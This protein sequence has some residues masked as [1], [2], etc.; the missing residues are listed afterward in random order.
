ML[1]PGQSPPAEGEGSDSS[2]SSSSTGGGS[3]GGHGLSTGAIVGIAIS[4]TAFV[5]ILVA[6]FFFIGRNRVYHHWMSSEDGR[7]E[8]TA[9]WLFQ[10]QTGTRD[11][12]ESSTTR[13]PPTEITTISSPDSAKGLLTPPMDASPNYTTS[14][15]HTSGQWS[16]DDRQNLRVNRGPTELEADSVPRHFSGMRDYR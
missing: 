5:A 2:S 10:S 11:G 8:R 12:T 9:R 6:L 1:V 13:R 16:W 4:C 7:N 15:H 14:P 3:S